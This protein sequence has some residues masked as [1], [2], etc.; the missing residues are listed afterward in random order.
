MKF[1]LSGF[2]HLSPAT[3]HGKVICMLYSLLGIPINGIFIVS[4][5]TYFQEKVKKLFSSIE[6]SRWKI[7]DGRRSVD[8]I[9]NE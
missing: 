2:G 3:S 4:I 8:K 6:D 1:P 5:S 9:H 7:V